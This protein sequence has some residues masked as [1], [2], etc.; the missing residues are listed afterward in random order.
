MALDK[1]GKR[2]VDRA[3]AKTPRGT[4]PIVLTCKDRKWGPV[5]PK[6]K[7]AIAKLIC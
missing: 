2:M 4:R 3:M 7:P 6:D 1:R 5:P